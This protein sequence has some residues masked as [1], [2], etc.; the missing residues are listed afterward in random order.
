VQCRLG[1][2]IAAAG[3]EHVLEDGLKLDLNRLARKGFIKPGKNIGTRGISWSNSYQGEI[4]R[5][6]I[7][8]RAAKARVWASEG[9]G[10]QEGPLAAG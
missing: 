1:L 10:V 9:F 7:E 4:A 2:D 6:V 8:P 3:T 5:G